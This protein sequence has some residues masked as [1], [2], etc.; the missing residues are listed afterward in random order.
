MTWLPESV[1]KKYDNEEK[2]SRVRYDVGKDDRREV[3]GNVIMDI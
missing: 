2:A 1:K 3:G